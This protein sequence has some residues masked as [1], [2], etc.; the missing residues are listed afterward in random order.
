MKFLFF[1][2]NQVWAG[3][4]LEN[5]TLYYFE[6]RQSQSDCEMDLWTVLSDIDKE[7]GCLDKLISQ[8]YQPTFGL[9]DI[10]QNPN[11]IEKI[12]CSYQF[13]KRK[14]NPHKFKYT[15]SAAFICDLE[16]YSNAF[17]INAKFFSH[18]LSELK[19]S[20]QI[21]GEYYCSLIMFLKKQSIIEFTQ[22]KNY[23]YGFPELDNL[24]DF[25][26]DTVYIKFTQGHNMFFDNLIACA[27]NIDFHDETQPDEYSFVT[28]IEMQYY[29]SS[30]LRKYGFDL[31]TAP[32]K[33]VERFR[34]CMLSLSSEGDVMGLYY[35]GKT[36]I[37]EGNRVFERDVVTGLEYLN[38]LYGE[39]MNHH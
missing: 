27:Q 20:V 25:S 3:Y 16:S 23:G 4:D 9:N 26:M 8:S 37:C 21:T 12:F 5:K 1:R 2:V 36:C 29:T 11:D 24:F 17:S 32:K 19:E 28:D 14:D 30:M 13:I 34:D 7:K 6:D 35:I 33:E 38:Y 39:I 15:V 10:L 22:K 31:E 18:I